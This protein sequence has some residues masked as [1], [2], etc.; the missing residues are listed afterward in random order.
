MKRWQVIALAVAVVGAAAY[1]YFYRGF[2]LGGS[3]QSAL[4]SLSGPAGSRPADIKWAPVNRPVDGFKLERPA[5]PKEV[6]VPAQH[7]VALLNR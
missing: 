2:R 6:Q 7:Q 1:F 5:D 3:S 4:G